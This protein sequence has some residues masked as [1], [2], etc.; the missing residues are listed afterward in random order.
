MPSPTNK[1]APISTGLHPASANKK[2]DKTPRNSP[3]NAHAGGHTPR[4]NT[5]ALLP[6]VAP[7]DPKAFTKKARKTVN[8]KGNRGKGQ[9]KSGAGGVIVDSNDKEEPGSGGGSDGSSN[10]EYDDGPELGSAPTAEVQMDEL[11]RAAEERAANGVLASR[12]PLHSP[13]PPVGPRLTRLLTEPVKITAGYELITNPAS[14][15]MLFDPRRGPVAR[16]A[17]LASSTG[18]TDESDW[19]EL[20]MDGIEV[21]VQRAKY[22]EVVKKARGAPTAPAAAIAVVGGA[23]A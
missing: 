10:G 16:R 7:P 8:I 15:P 20:N 18:F 13:L 22:A 14:K 4:A 17:S 3:S 5:N 9:S 6:L 21:P 1:T 23:R 11:V 2:K 12:N 19:C